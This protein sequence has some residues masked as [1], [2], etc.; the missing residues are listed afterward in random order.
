MAEILQFTPKNK[1]DAAQNVEDFVTLCRDHLSVFGTNLAWDD[2]AWDVTDAIEKRGRN[3]R[4]AFAWT[5]H[6]TSKTNTKA[7]LMAEPFLSFA[8]SY[9]RSQHAMKPTKVF[10]F[11]ISA[12]RALERSLTE[13]FKGRKPDITLSDPSVF[14]YAQALIKAKFSESAAYRI[15]G[16]LEMI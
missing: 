16:Q 9:M 11:R 8:K 7:D 15:S 1:T 6:D 13:R 14:N 5:N 12:L 4:L 10:G 3:G 2:R